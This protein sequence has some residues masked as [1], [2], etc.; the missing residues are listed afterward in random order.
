MQ[1]T[2][3][4]LSLNH[5]KKA[6]MDDPGA[7]SSYS[8]KESWSIVQFLNQAGFQTGNLRKDAETLQRVHTVVSFSIFS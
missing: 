1:P 5:Q 7:D 4:P 2:R 6:K 8:N 3:V